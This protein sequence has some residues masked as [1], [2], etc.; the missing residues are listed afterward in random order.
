MHRRSHIAFKLA[1]HIAVRIV[2]GHHHDP[3]V[4]GARP[5]DTQSLRGAP[6]DGCEVAGAAGELGARE[7]VLADLVVPGSADRLAGRL[8]A[9][10]RVHVLAVLASGIVLHAIGFGEILR[11]V[12]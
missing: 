11:N 1:H 4:G 2:I 6:D 3:S 5:T 8:E 10:A 9:A 7:I 12:L